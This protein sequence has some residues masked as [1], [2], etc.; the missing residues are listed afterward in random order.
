MRDIYQCI[1]VVFSLLLVATQVSCSGSTLHELARD[2]ALEA[3]EQEPKAIRQKDTHMEFIETSDHALSAQCSNSYLEN[4]FLLKVDE[5][6]EKDDYASLRKLS[7]ITMMAQCN[8]DDRALLLAKAFDRIGWMDKEVWEEL[9]NDVD[10]ELRFRSLIRSKNEAIYN[11]EEFK[12]LI[13]NNRKFKKYFREIIKEAHDSKNFAF[14]RIVPHPSKEYPLEE[15]GAIFFWSLACGQKWCSDEWGNYINTVEDIE[16]A[17]RASQIFE[18]DNPKVFECERVKEFLMQDGTFSESLET[19]I[20]FDS[21]SFAKYLKEKYADEPEEFQS[22]VAACRSIHTLGRTLVGYPQK[23]HNKYRRE[24]LSRIYNFL[25]DNGR[26]L[27]KDSLEI[28]FGDYPVLTEDYYLQFLRYRIFQRG[29]YYDDGELTLYG[30]T[31]TGI[32]LLKEFLMGECKH[33]G[34]QI[35]PSW[36]H[37]TEFEL[38]VLDLEVFK[39]FKGLPT[40]GFEGWQER[41]LMNCASTAIR[42]RDIKFL[43]DTAILTEIPYYYTAMILS[44]EAKRGNLTVLDWIF[45]ADKTPTPYHH[46]LMCASLLEQLFGQSLPR[47]ASAKYTSDYLRW[48]VRKGDRGLYDQVMAITGAIKVIQE[49]GFEIPKFPEEGEGEGRVKTNQANI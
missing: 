46:S 38:E 11:N 33:E 32:K 34:E 47:K 31:D 2:D 40:L 9:C 12:N 30:Q 3:G 8:E 36:G 25:L 39:L 26:D 18:G 41:F 1:L 5:A 14:L 22:M 45:T 43:A 24:R 23:A 35:N 13:F 37:F 15:A 6:I 4:D 16:A 48:T 20:E 10:W 49:H 42:K 17:L 27:D 28:V 44:D 29:P 21:M 19:A 7:S